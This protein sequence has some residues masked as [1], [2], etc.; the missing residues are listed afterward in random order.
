M[1]EKVEVLGLE[2][3]DREVVLLSLVLALIFPTVG[4]L[5][6]VVELLA[7]WWKS[8]IVMWNCWPWS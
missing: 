3:L 7:H 1:G 5:A 2:V 4:E 6:L 8:W